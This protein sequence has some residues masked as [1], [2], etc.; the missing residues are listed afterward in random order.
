V[1]RGINVILKGVDMVLRGFDVILKGVGMV[2]I[3]G[4]QGFKM[5]GICFIIHITLFYM[6]SFNSNVYPLF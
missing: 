2:L 6:P 3:G 5:W 4:N 1:L